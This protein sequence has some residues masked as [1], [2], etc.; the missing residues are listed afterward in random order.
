MNQSTMGFHGLLCFSLVEFQMEYFNTAYMGQ[1][2]TTPRGIDFTPIRCYQITNLLR[3][4]FSKQCFISVNSMLI[5]NEK[6]NKFNHN[7]W[8]LNNRHFLIYSNIF[9]FRTTSKTWLVRRYQLLHHLEDF[10]LQAFP[11]EYLNW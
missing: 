3:C 2:I 11:I 5:L 9:L 8:K 6:W 1:Y 10:V 7:L 4:L